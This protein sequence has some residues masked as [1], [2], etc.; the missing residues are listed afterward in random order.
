VRS[1][2]F[3]V[4]LAALAGMLADAAA[5][6]PAPPHLE[7][8]GL[9]EY[10]EYLEAP[11]HRAFAI[12]PGGAWGWT[13]GEAT[14]Q[15]AEANALAICRK[16]TAQR[17]VIH[18]LDGRTVFDTAGW[19]RLWGPYADGAAA[20]R[21]GVGRAPGQRLPDL[22]FNAPD[23]KPRRLSS[24][25]GKVVL[26][27]F[28]GAWYPP[29][30]REMPE[31]QK[32][33]AA[34]AGRPDVVFVLLQAREKLAVSR[35]WAAGQG[36]GLPL[37]DSGSSGEEDDNFHLGG[38][39]TIRDREIAHR[40]PTTYVLD[41]RGLIVFAHVGPVHDWPAYESFLRDAADRSGR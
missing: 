7:A 27:H 1:R 35:Q 38:G 15:A 24:Y 19:P 25:R 30:R 22:A 6:P 29:C 14:A 8:S 5:T 34:L 10:R 33:H 40:F 21:A 31:L 2:V 39:R 41:K 13:S 32:L 17:C 37:H 26:L 16:Q 18:G 36:I 3:S 11:D 9:V 20:A 12:A 4:A 23:G 28:W